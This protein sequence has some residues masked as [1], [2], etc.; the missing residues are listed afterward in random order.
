[1]QPNFSVKGIAVRRNRRLGFV[2]ATGMYEASEMRLACTKVAIPTNSR[3]EFHMSYNIQFAIRSHAGIQHAASSWS[4]AEAM[5][6]A[7]Q[8]G[9]PQ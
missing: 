8:S 4:F 6:Q 5:L 9:I 3:L 2:T 7:V 1:M